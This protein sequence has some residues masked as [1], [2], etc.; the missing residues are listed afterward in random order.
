MLTV[1]DLPMGA[2]AAGALA[3]GPFLFARAFRDL[4]VRRLIRDTPRARIRSMPMGLV[5]VY[6]SAEPRSTLAA[7]FS[8]RPCVC[9]QVDVSTR[10]RNRTWNVVHREASAHVFYLR[11]ETGL[12]MVDPRGAD[13][14]LTWQVEEEC[15]GLS[16]PDC[17]AEYLKAR[18]P[19]LGHLWGM[20]TLRFR[21]RTLE[22]GQ[23]V[24]VLATAT[25][26]A[27]SV[28]ISDDEG[29][30]AT[31]TDDRRALRVP[32]LDAEARGVLRRG[33]NET[34]FLVSQQSELELT[35]SLGLHA[36]L[37]LVAGPALTLFGLG[38]G[39]L[40]LGAWLHRP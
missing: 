24:Y 33:T 8:G 34:T 37:G 7:P 29:W 16:L 13:L 10:G 6:G 40:A 14:R 5:E 3:S 15:A 32:A 26:R 9:W 20:G 27:A 28:S 30:A 11:D 36:A 39:L 12:A 38:Y 18:H 2:V 25:P 4:R 35:T 21:E 19:V 22:E 23:R 31:G 1:L 17:Y